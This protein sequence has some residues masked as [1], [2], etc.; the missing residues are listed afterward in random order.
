MA[1]DR[2]GIVFSSHHV[3]AGVQ[4]PVHRTGIP[5]PNPL[6]EKPMPDH[7]SQDT[8]KDTFRKINDLIKDTRIA[9][10]TT[11]QPD[12][13]IHSRPM[14]T[15]IQPFDGTLWFL[16]REQSGK[17]SEIQQDAHVALT[18]SDPRHIYVSLTGRASL[19]NDRA[20][21]HELWNPACKS[22]FPQGEQ[23]PDITILK[24]DVESAEYWEAPANALVRNF[25][26]L[27]KAVSGG[28]AKVGEHEKIEVG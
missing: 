25:Q 28:S 24:V 13:R 18:Y 23:D 5:H 17:V 7:G 9:M 3:E 22:W 11:V 12:G 20:K 26:I 16:T 19:S 4:R 27:R 6:K 15:Q 8:C 10:L 14:A 1:T 21:I 2:V